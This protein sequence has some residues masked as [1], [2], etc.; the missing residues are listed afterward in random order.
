MPY[1]IYLDPAAAAENVNNSPTNPLKSPVVAEH[2]QHFQNFCSL[3][4]KY[5]HTHIYILQYKLDLIVI[6]YMMCASSTAK[7]HKTYAIANKFTIIS[8]CVKSLLAQVAFCIFIF[9]IK[10]RDP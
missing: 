4:S 1:C 6:I 10:T 2:F 7:H 8:I 5:F 9:E 3:V